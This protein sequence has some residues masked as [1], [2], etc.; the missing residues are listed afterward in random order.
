MEQINK[1]IHGTNNLNIK[2]IGNNINNSIDSSNIYNNSQINQ[3]NNVEDTINY[4]YSISEEEKQADLLFDNLLNVQQ[5]N[6]EHLKALFD[7]YQP[8]PFGK[9]WGND[10]DYVNL[11]NKLK[12]MLSSGKKIKISEILNEKKSTGNNKKKIKSNKTKKSK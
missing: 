6:V 11:S 9:A 8:K 10:P 3:E 4:N 5:Q 7:E 12:A 2:P 1:N